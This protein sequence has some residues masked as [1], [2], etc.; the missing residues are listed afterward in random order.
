MINT[1][2]LST[3]D[4]NCL[5]ATI[6]RHVCGGI[7]Y[8][9]VD[10]WAA[11]AVHLDSWIENTLERG[12]E[13]WKLENLVEVIRSFQPHHIRILDSGTGKLL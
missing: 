7:D 2:N 13:P 11:S 6:S 4:N 5:E 10:F 12:H 9:E 1:S 3:I 8:F